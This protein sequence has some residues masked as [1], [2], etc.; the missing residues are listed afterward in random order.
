MDNKACIVKN[1]C[2]NVI[3]LEKDLPERKSK[4]QLILVIKK[5]V[6]NVFKQ[7]KGL[8]ILASPLSSN[9]TTNEACRYLIV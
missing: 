5:N 6:V 7:R 1:N 8:A 2:V 3:C 9:N 4:D